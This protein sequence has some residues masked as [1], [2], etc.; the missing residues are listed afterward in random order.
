MSDKQWYENTGYEGTKTPKQYWTVNGKKYYDE[1]KAKEAAGIGAK[2]TQP[3]P[4]R[5]KPIEISPE[6]KKAEEALK[7]DAKRESIRDIKKKFP[8]GYRK[9][10]DDAKAEKEKTK[11]PPKAPPKTPPTGTPITQPPFVPSKSKKGAPKKSVGITAAKFRKMKQ[12]E[13]APVSLTEEWEQD[14]YTVAQA[15]KAWKKYQSK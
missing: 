12:F 11:T 6:R 10:V 7:A 3:K 8:D 13:F 2:K 4:E 1:D 15:E 5:M 14:G 9:M